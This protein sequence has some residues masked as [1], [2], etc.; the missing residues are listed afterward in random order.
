M[1]IAESPTQYRMLTQSDH[2]DLAGQ[3]AAH[4]GN[5]RFARPEPFPTLALLGATHDDGWWEWDLH[6]HLGPNG[7]PINFNRMPPDRPGFTAGIDVLVKKQPYAGLLNS[8]HYSGLRRQRYGL[9]PN[10]PARSDEYSDRFV[11]QQEALQK[12]LLAELRASGQY[13]GYASEERVW[14][15][16]RLLQVWDL[17]S[18]YFCCNYRLEEHVIKHVPVALGAE[19]TELHLYPTGEAEVRVEPYPFDTSPF[20]VSVRGRLLP[21]T[22]YKTEEELMEHWFRAE[23]KLFTFTVYS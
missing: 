10:M 7:K 14:F 18:L 1:I 5:D 23:R 9:D 4:W 21:K 12:Q 13:E 17:L 16:Y 2:G 8:M 15:N 11:Q 20:V 3:F 22:E 19:D 6:P